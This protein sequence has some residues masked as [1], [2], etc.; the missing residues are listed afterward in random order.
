MDSWARYGAPQAVPG[1]LFNFAAYL[2]AAMKREPHGVA[3]CVICL[4]AMFL[5][6][7]LLV[8]GALPF[9]DAFRTRPMAQ[10]AMRARTR[11]SSASPRPGS[12]FGLWGWTNDYLTKAIT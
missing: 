12:F 7:L 10:A 9:W 2:G 4:L 8:T 11:P 1:P 6:D 3:G 5:P